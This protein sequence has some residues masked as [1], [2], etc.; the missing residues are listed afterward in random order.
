MIF[1]TVGSQLPFDR[2]IRAVDDWCSRRQVTD[3]FAQIADPGPRG[4]VPQHFEW[5]RFLSPEEFDRRFLEARLI[6]AHAGMGSIISAL[7]ANKPIVIMPRR[8]SLNE[9]RN[10][11]Q[12]ATVKKFHDRANVH[13]AMDETELAG[14]VDSAHN[15]PIRGEERVRPHAEQS[16]ILSLRRFILERGRDGSG[17]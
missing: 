6:I 1:V 8:A 2:L 9:H 16:L 11:H 3:V 7:M 15:Q 10:D 14:V 12:H 5:E 13:V 17:S 4:Y